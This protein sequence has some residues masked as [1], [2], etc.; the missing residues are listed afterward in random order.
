MQAG[1]ARGRD[2]H[3]DQDVQAQRRRSAARRLARRV[4]GPSQITRHLIA[5][6]LP[7]ELKADRQQ[8][9]QAEVV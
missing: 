7:L 8:Q 1:I 9:V 6:L 4:L 3:P 5:E 2:L